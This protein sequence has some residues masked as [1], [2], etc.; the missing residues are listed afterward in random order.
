MELCPLQIEVTGEETFLS[1][2]NK[3]KREVREAM[4][5][6]QVGS[7][8]SLQGRGF[9][10]MFNMHPMPQYKFDSAGVI[11]ERVHPGHGSETL[12]LSVIDEYNTGSFSLHFDFH[13]D[14]FTTEER[15]R[16]VE[17]FVK[18]VDQLIRSS[19]K[20]TNI[21]SPI[22]QILDGYQGQT[23]TSDL[24]EK[25]PARSRKIIAPRDELESRLLHIWKEVLE[26]KTISVDDNFF[27]I[28]G[29][30][31]L[32]LKLFSKIYKKTGQDLPLSLLFQAATIE[33][34]SK[35]LSEKTLIK[36]WSP[37][38]IVNEGEKDPPLFCVH[39]AGGHILIYDDLAQ[40][41][42]SDQPFY[43]I[44]ARGVDGEE[45]T[46]RVEE[47]AK[48][49]LEAVKK[50]QPQGPYLI[51]GYSFGG[52]V[53][54]EMAQQIIKQGQ[55]VLLLAIIDVPAQSPYLKTLMN[56]IGKL[57]TVFQLK[58]DV[59]SKWFLRLR[60]YVVRSR[61]FIN[62]DNQAKRIYLQSVI[63]KMLKVAGNQDDQGRRSERH[64]LLDGFDMDDR[65][66]ENIKILEM[67]KLNQQAYEEYIPEKYSGDAVIFRSSKGYKNVD[68]DYSSDPYLGWGKVV[69]G[70]IKTFE[71]PGDHNSMIRE[72]NVQI[73]ADY[74]RSNL[75]DAYAQISSLKRRSGS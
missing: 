21:N 45:A 5:Y 64:L 18:L 57:G 28:G 43:A 40:H 14:V 20:L 73:L 9:D 19:P 29:N 3:V 16:S 63:R 75:N 4:A 46:A 23:P 6:Y 60:H 53:A 37:I 26:I 38:V 39:G 42:G 55:K 30:S 33:E 8:L 56:L 2:I 32:A 62:L 13:Q 12:A 72:P 51:G 50:V 61:Y 15:S 11:L 25:Q 17:L 67:F 22:S 10:V 7:S 44:Q 35:V 34:L 69:L 59:R 54:F 47:M 24:L 74:L 36:S 41:L 70:K 68:Y 27:E 65:S 52:V 1:V 48:H 31:W 49:Y 66:E 71:I 58:D